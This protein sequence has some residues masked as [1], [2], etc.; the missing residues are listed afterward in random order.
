[1]VEGLRDSEAVSA[2]FGDRLRIWLDRN[3]RALW[4]DAVFNE[5][6]ARIYGICVPR[7][8]LMIE[9]GGIQEAKWCAYRLLSC[10][11]PSR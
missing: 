1:M 11:W 5:T 6:A 7:T 3:A 10:H 9:C 8:F 2:L 4:L